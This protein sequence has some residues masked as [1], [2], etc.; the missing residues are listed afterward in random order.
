MKRGSIGSECYFAKKRKRKNKNPNKE[1]F[2]L[3]AETML[4]MF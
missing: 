3:M 1:K 4:I 2:K